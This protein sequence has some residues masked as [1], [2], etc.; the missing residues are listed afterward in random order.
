MRSG[1]RARLARLSAGLD[2]IEEE[3][4][5]QRYWLRFE[6]MAC[7]AVREAMQRAGVDPS[8]ATALQEAEARVAAFIDTPEL[9]AAD[10][11]FR[12]AE[13]AASGPDPDDPSEELIAELGRFQRRFAETG[14]LPD[15]RSASLM[16]LLA[17]A[18]PPDL[19]AELYAS[20]S[21]LC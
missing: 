15:F 8:C 9:Q 7:E 20:G 10:A 12:A 6:A 14:K 11:A 5:G 1:H 18:S 4:V 2:E 16:V 3:V 19:I 21:G 13:K 17:W